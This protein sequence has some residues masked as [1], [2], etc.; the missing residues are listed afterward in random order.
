MIDIE[1]LKKELSNAN[2][3]AK[4]DKAT[5]FN[6]NLFYYGEDSESFAVSIV[7]EKDKIVLTDL[8]ITVDRLSKQDIDINDEDIKG[9]VNAV[10]STLQVG[11]GP[12]N[13]LTVYASDE[14]DCVYAL[15]RL[16][17]A[18]IL[19]SYIDLQF[20]YED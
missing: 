13:E 4:Y 17:Q 2:S 15:G 19:L 3:F 9:Y 18:M 11:M 12:T 8:G 16:Q 1:K 14:K 20:E 5:V 6:G 7:E 10:L